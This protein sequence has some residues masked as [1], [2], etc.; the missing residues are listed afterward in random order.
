MWPLAIKQI[1]RLQ[2]ELTTFCNADCPSCERAN[3]KTEEND[4]Y[5][6][7]LNTLS[8]SLDDIKKWLPLDQ[9]TSLT[10]IHFCGNVDEPTVHPQLIDICTYLKDFEI[11]ISTNGG[12]RHKEFWQSLAKLKN[13]LVIF[14]IDG[15]EDTNHIY[16]QNVSWKKLQENYTT[17]I[18]C[19]GRAAWQFIVF[20]HN[21][22]QIQQAL[23]ISKQ[24]G[25]KYFNTVY[26]TRENHNV[27]AVPIERKVQSCIKCKAT[28]DNKELKE[29]FYIDAVG[30]VW[31]C[32]WMATNFQSNKIA[33]QIGD[34]FGY[35]L[36]H[37]LRYDTLEN[38]VAGDMFS[39]L[40]NHLSDFEVC[41]THCLQNISD[42]I[43]WQE[44]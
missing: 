41:N 13:V 17:Y 23:N 35:Y 28:Y 22:H 42:T 21:K 19:G 43:T 36:S 6:K 2:I 8:I 5:V 25:F 12:T 16:R 26:S 34:Q 18:K 37:N 11:W 3:Y 10:E 9:F 7:H 31:P 29:S 14:G 20:E 27:K 15:L 39:Y 33:K 24:E 38:I 30:T 32:C 4:V 44:T 1:K 40:W